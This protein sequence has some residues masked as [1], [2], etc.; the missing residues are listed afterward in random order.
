MPKRQFAAISVGACLV[1]GLA[2]LTLLSPA[3]SAGVP[4]IQTFSDVPPEHACASCADGG[5][6]CED[7]QSAA[8]IGRSLIGDF[9]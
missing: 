4:S 7:L 8:S 5:F 2:A 9:G 6:S 3:F 1:V